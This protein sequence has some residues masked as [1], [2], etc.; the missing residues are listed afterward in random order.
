MDN[1]EISRLDE[2]LKKNA[3][4]AEA[5]LLSRKKAAEAKYSLDVV[6]GAGFLFGELPEK[7]SYDKAILIISMK[8]N[9]L[10]TYKDL[11]LY[12]AEYKG[13]EKVLEANSEA[14]RW[15]QSKMK[16]QETGERI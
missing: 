3:E 16:W 5:Y 1:I 13:L 8:K 2:V 12:T 15:A 11:I 10:Q 9:M 6:I 7:I 14:I 4:N